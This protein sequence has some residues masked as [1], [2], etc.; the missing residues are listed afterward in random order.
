MAISVAAVRKQRESKE[1]TTKHFTAVEELES[2]IDAKITKEIIENENSSVSIE[3]CYAKFTH[4]SS[5]N[6]PTT[7]SESIRKKMNRELEKRYKSKG[8]QIHY[9][10]DDRLDG[11]MSGADYFVL[12]L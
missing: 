6:F 9:D 7:Y 2:I 8:W 1:L 4:N 11:N 12:S 3:L 10:L 5:N